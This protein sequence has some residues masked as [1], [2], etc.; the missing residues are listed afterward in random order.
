MFIHPLNIYFKSLPKPKGKNKL[1]F[2]HMQQITDSSKRWLSLLMLFARTTSQAHRENCAWCVHKMNDSFT[3]GK[4]SHC[5]EWLHSFVLPLMLREPETEDYALRRETSEYLN[6]SFKCQADIKS[7][8][9][10][11]LGRKL[12]MQWIEHLVVGHYFI[13]WAC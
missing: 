5:V 2:Q 6:N 10:Q 13:L 1:S 8:W 11:I 4:I 3:A 7:D 12:M 9:S